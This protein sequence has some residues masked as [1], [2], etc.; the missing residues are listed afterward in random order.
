MTWYM[1]LGPL[2]EEHIASYTYQARDWNSSKKEKKKRNPPD[3][4]QIK[5]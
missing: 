5:Y 3:K 4:M 1:R 2:K